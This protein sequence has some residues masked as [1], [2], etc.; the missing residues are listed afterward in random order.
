MCVTSTLYISVYKLTT[1]GVCVCF[2]HVAS[3]WTDL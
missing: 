2:H 3:Y 1:R